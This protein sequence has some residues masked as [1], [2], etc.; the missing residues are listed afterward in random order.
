[1]VELAK[2][3]TA[4]KPFCVVVTTCILLNAALLGVE[5]SQTIM[6][7]AGTYMNVF[8]YIFKA[9]FLVEIILRLIA[10]HP[11]Y[12][13][14]FKDGW[15]VFDFVIVA[16]TTV[17]LGG[18]YANVGRVLRLLRVIRLV[19]VSDELKLIVSTMFRSIPSMGHVIL[20]LSMLLYVYGVAGFY[21]FHTVDPENWGTLGRSLLSLFQVVTL[22]GW[23]D[24]QRNVLPQR[25]WAWL[26]FATFI[27]I[28]VFVVINLFI[29]VVMN[30]LDKAK[31]EQRALADSK[32]PGGDIL[33]RLERLK[34]E[35]DEIE[36]YIRNKG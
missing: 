28:G 17:P 14:F 9:I 25:P 10:F 20:L 6:A 1:M 8:N 11:N 30:N 13:R 5:T 27:V 22:E 18:D 3:W 32:L 33:A 7:A 31:E 4:S 24:F 29:A 26:Y 2:K 12:R 16:I 35:I 21:M 15:N 19:T 34:T 36:R 23:P